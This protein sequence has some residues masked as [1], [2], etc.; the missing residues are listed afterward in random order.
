MFIINTIRENPAALLYILP[1]LVMTLT[2]HELC[3]GLAAY[4]LGDSTAKE[5]GR[6]SLNPL[7]HID[8]MGFL[9]LMIAGFG[10]AKPVGVD[11]RN[12]KKPKR[13]FALVAAAGPFSNFILAFLFTIVFCFLGGRFDGSYMTYPSHLNDTAVNALA[14]AILINLGL[15]IFNMFPIPPLDGS[16][17][18]AAFLPDRLYAQYLRLGRYGMFIIFA[19]AAFGGL[20]DILGRLRSVMVEGM[21]TVAEPPVRLILD[22]L[23]R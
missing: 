3:H 18:V 6:L 4:A 14:Y 13:D 20:T 22:L 9:M 12:L 19:I 5:Q 17:L 11:L 16:R 1:I 2:V 21:F 15:G 10:W 23:S 7:R 8:W